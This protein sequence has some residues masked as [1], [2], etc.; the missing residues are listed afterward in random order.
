MKRKYATRGKI[1]MRVHVYIY[2]PRGG[3]REIMREMLAC[4][5]LL[6]NFRDEFAVTSDC[7]QRLY[8]SKFTEAPLYPGRD[9][10][11]LCSSYIRICRDRL[12]RVIR[13]KT[14]EERMQGKPISVHF[15]YTCL[16]GMSWN[17]LF[18]ERRV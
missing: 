16:W 14:F 11:S 7:A 2:T 8:H 10:H 18:T 1:R 3:G 12:E 4:A 13:G 15:V 9:C 17:T 5:G 6:V